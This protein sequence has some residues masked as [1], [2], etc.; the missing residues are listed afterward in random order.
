MRSAAQKLLVCAYRGTEADRHED[1]TFREKE[2]EATRRTVCT[3]AD[4][5]FSKGSLQGSHSQGQAS[6]PVLYP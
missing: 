3:S 5:A 6:R 1:N 2:E 4:Q